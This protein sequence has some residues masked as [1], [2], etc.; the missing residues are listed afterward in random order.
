MNDIKEPTPLVIISSSPHIH[1]GSS[2]SAGMRDVLLALIP[3]LLAAIYY[4]RQD[5]LIL[6]LTCII[7]TVCFEALC[8]KVMGRPIT[9]KDGSAI[10]TGLL[11]AF[12]LPPSL[13]LGLAIF[14]SFCAIIIGKGVF[15]G[16][17]NNLFNPAHLGRAILLA[18][19]PQQMTTWI[20]PVTA[21][22]VDSVTHATI[23]VDSITTA[24]PLALLRQSE[25]LWQ[26]GDN[27]T[28]IL[29]S[30]WQMFLGNTGGSLGETCIP[31]ILLGGIYLL[32]RKIID[33]RIPVFYIGTVATITFIYGYFHDYNNFFALYHLCA[34][35]LMIGAF[36]MATDWVTSPITKKGRIIYALGLG[37]LTA[38]IRLRGSYVE[39]VCYSILIMNMMTPLIDRYVRTIPF[40]GGAKHEE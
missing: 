10:L 38:L 11:L 26:Q 3:T 7:S 5:A 39:G 12:C 36:F 16:L 8:Q 20:N 30:L 13:P 40:G 35:G 34:G 4:F 6:I 1:C 37:L 32:Y 27:A 25:V 9:T 19:F 18:S 24:T 22:V 21:K 29:P 14:G 23:N 17:G 28:N 33:W 2:I 15:G 31:A